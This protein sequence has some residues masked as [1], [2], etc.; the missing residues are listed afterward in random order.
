M[1]I[2][3]KEDP[4]DLIGKIGDANFSICDECDRH[5]DHPETIR[6]R[7]C[8]DAVWIDVWTK[9]DNE[10]TM[11]SAKALCQLLNQD[12]RKVQ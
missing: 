6:I 3:C 4:D 8:E 11:E 5:K 2:E 12:Y 1:I 7:D 10:T 9:Y